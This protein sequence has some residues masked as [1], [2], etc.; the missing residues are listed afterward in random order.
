MEN[1]LDS[2][3]ERQIL[4]NRKNIKQIIEAVKLRGR[5]DIALRGHRYVGPIISDETI[6]ENEGNF[7]AVLRYRRAGDQSLK[8]FQEGPGKETNTLVQ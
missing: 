5:Q 3:R 4:L 1:L 6:L 7:R 8:E 2:D